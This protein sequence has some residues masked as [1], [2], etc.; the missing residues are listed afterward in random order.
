MNDDIKLTAEQQKIVAENHKLIYWYANLYRLDLDEWY[1]ILAIELCVAVQK[2]DPELGSLSRF[3]KVSAD[4]RRFKI[5]RDAKRQKRFA[6]K[7]VSL[8]EIGDIIGE[9]D[10]EIP[11][12]NY[13]WIEPDVKRII[14]YRI[15]GYTQAEI[16]DKME[17]SQSQISKILARHRGELFEHDG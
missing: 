13:E 14:D 17:M 1:D 11:E 5:Y 4:S 9:E 12:I 3:F 15:R 6:K 2:Y 10:E 8:D 7:M 16:A